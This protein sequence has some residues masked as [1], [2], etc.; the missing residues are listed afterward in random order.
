MPT[1]KGTEIALP[2]VRAPGMEPRWGVRRGRWTDLGFW[3]TGDLPNWGT[4][5]FFAYSG[6]PSRLWGARSTAV[7]KV[8]IYLPV[9]PGTRLRVTMTP[10]SVRRT[11]G[12]QLMVK[13]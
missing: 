9:C 6:A 8:V 11:V 4:G 1:G 2:G 10:N 12:A 7:Q 5:P 13:R 3:S